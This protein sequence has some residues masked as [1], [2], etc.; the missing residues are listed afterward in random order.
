MDNEEKQVSLNN[1]ENSSNSFNKSSDNL[2]GEIDSIEV[3][4]NSQN[5][6]LNNNHR[7]GEIIVSLSGN[8]E[9]KKLTLLEVIA[10]FSP[11]K[12][13]RNALDDI[14]EGKTG[15]LIVVDNPK[16]RNLLD[17]GFRINCVLTMQKLCELAKM[18]GAII[19]SDDLKRILMA[20]VLLVPD[21][22][23]PTNE[24]GT[25]HKAAERVARQT[26]TLVIAVS[27][28]RNKISVFYDD[29]KYILEDSENI[30]RRATETLNILE[31]QREIFDELLKNLNILEITRLV[32]IADICSLLQR[33]EVILKMMDTMKRYLTELGNQGIIL[34]M[35]VKE[36]S[37]DIDIIESQLLMDYSDKPLNVK[38][39]IDNIN[40]EGLLDMESFSRLL[41]EVSPDTSIS[42]RGHRI[43]GKLN[44]TERE[45]KALISTF[46]NLS[47]ILD[48]SEEEL[49][50]ILK[51]KAASFKH[52]L[53]NLKEQ[54]LVGKKI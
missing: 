37:K 30:L 38:K 52:E 13:L 16:V 7:P 8:A 48:A 22:K 34:R 10:K 39:I 21:S 53:S 31:K 54:I 23:I 40:F 49:S 36:L 12:N 24:T 33:I 50:K 45:I 19:I 42:P 29:K 3:Q 41:F 47:N 2:N 6:S 27:E 46:Q 51:A 14:L 4:N 15:A 20:N 43:L 9:E 18:D 32:S 5:N 11:G 35:R 17:G 25:R 1:S 44:L 26:G 28:R